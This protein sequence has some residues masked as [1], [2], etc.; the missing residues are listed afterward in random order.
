M[1]NIVRVLCLISIITLCFLVI[2]T[3]ITIKLSLDNNNYV[4]YNTTI[5]NSTCYYSCCDFDAICDKCYSCVIL[6]KFYVNNTEITTYYQNICSN[7]DYDSDCVS[8]INT[9]IS[10]NSFILYYYD[11]DIIYTLDTPWTPIIIMVLLLLVLFFMIT[12]FTFIFI[13][14]IIKKIKYIRSEYKKKQTQ[15]S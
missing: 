3:Y 14:V 7:V 11:N 4:Q 5:I 10:D 15:N 9:K 12:M 2:D 8:D 6:L 13:L 1:K